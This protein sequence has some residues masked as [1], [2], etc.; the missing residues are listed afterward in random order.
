MM[1]LKNLIY[2]FD[3]SFVALQEV[4]TVEKKGNNLKI[5]TAFT[6]SPRKISAKKLQ[7]LR[8]LKTEISSRFLF[9]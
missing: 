6:E 3:L 9:L 4:K 2:V 5:W 8:F 1:T 7:V